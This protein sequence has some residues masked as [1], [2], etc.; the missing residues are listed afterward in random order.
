MKKI[1][2][3]SAGFLFLLASC[4]G[5]KSSKDIKVGEIK[6]AC[7]WLTDIE[8]VTN[9]YAAFLEKT[10]AEFKAK[11]KEGEV[12]EAEVKTFEEK[13]S[14]YEKLLEDLDKLPAEKKWGSEFGE[15]KDFLSRMAAVAMLEEKIMSTLK[16]EIQGSMSSVTLCAQEY[17]KALKDKDWD[18]AKTMATKETAQ[19][20]DMMNSLGTDFGLTEVK[21]VKCVTVGNEATCT[22]CCT[23]D[24]S[25]K[26]LKLKK[27]GKVWLAHQPKEIPPTDGDTLGTPEI[28]ESE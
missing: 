8:I 27:E 4:G 20:L 10:A 15:C 19:N 13:A 12:P 22:F 14:F 21:D 24:T 2:F 25:F 16:P 5:K 28:V 23:K 26:E 6:T 7:E 1:I 17:L 11:Y 3:I 9:E 18:K